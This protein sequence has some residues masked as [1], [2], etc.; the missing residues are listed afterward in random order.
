MEQLKQVKALLTNPAVETLSAGADAVYLVPMTHQ[1]QTLDVAIKCFGR[2]SL[3]KDRYEQ[4]NASKAERSFLAADYLL[5]HGV[6]TPEPI[7][8]L[9]HWQGKQLSQSYDM[10]L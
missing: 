9:D 3:L 4:A 8:F 2:Q 5:A 7:A 1:G 10:L 6:G